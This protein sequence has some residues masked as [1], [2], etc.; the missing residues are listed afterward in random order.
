VYAIGGNE[1]ASRLSGINTKL[2][3]LLCFVFCGISA[4]VSGI[5]FASRINIGQANI[6]EGMPLDVLAAVLIGGTSLSGGAGSIWQTIVG[7]MLLGFLS[8]GFNL[9]NV[10]PFLQMTIKGLIIITAVSVE[11]LYQRKD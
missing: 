3:R 6:A 7:V 1:E 4:S 8:N 9:L 10:S 2:I 5:I 11:S